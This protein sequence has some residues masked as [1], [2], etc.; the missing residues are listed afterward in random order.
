MNYLFVGEYYLWFFW[1]LLK[2][3]FILKLNIIVERDKDKFMF[4]LESRVYNW[5]DF[6]KYVDVEKFGYD[7]YYKILVG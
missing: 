5:I 3:F 1:F 6:L 4:E 7:L 2:L